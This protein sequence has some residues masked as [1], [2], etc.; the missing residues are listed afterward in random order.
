MPYVSDRMLENL[1]QEDVPYIDL[2][3]WALGIGEQRGCMEYFTREKIVL[4]GSEEAARIMQKLGIEVKESMPSGTVLAPGEVFLCAEGFV[5]DLHMA[6][7]VCQNILDHCS[8]IATATRALLD[9]VRQ[10]NPDISIL[11]TRKSFPGTKPL[12]TKAVM[13]GGAVPHRLGLSETVLIFRQHMEFLGGVQGLIGALPSIR[14]KLSEKKVIV[15]AETP[16]EGAAFCQAGADGIQFDKLNVLELADAVKLLREMKPSAVILA[17]GGIHAQ[18][19]CGFAKT[20]IDGIVTTSMFSAKPV[21][22][23]VKMSKSV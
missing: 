16:E 4:C 15:E 20:G 18:N 3:T 14:K 11:T 13:V 17:A 22:M 2:T 7:K 19:A 6:W 8:G 10:V 12:V 9:E 5:R 21:D 23:G 1:L